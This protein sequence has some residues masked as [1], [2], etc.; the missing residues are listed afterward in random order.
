MKNKILNY[1][2][3]LFYPFTILN[4]FIF[5]FLVRIGKQRFVIKLI[6]KIMNCTTKAHVLFNLNCI[7]INVT[8]K[9]I[10]SYDCF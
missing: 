1:L 3:C 2:V 10:K 6:M 5:L 9:V 7:S 8:Q 4:Y